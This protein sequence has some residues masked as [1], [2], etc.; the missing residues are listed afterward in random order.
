MTASISYSRLIQLLLLVAF[1]LN[2]VSFLQLPLPKFSIFFIKFFPIFILTALLFY[3]CRFSVRGFSKFY[4]A[5]LVGVF[6]FFSLVYVFSD[7]A[8]EYV[9]LYSLW[10]WFYFIIFFGLS[11]FC[12]HNSSFSFDRFFVSVFWAIVFISC[13]SIIAIYLD[14]PLA[15]YHRYTVGLITKE[16]SGLFVST[17]YGTYFSCIALLVG[18][19]LRKQ[20][21]SIPFLLA[22]GIILL[23]IMLYHS[24]SQVLLLIA[25]LAVYTLAYRKVLLLTTCVFAS[26]I[27]AFFFQGTVEILN[28]FLRY[29]V[30][31]ERGILGNR[32]II[33]SLYWQVSDYFFWSGIGPG[34]TRNLWPMIQVSSEYEYLNFYGLN[35][36]SSFFTNVIEF[37]V[38]FALFLWAGYISV[39]F[40]SALHENKDRK[41]LVVL[42]AFILLDALLNDD[43]AYPGSPGT[44]IF[45]TVLA[46]LHTSNRKTGK[47]I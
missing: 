42:L 1:T 38:F 28:A 5:I 8:S 43:I 14:L 31:V 6:P 17:N 33:Y 36:H 15:T 10:A 26:I 20:I 18:F 24:R 29:D 12:L 2:F 25:C 37:G 19:Y 21:P 30:L 45:M 35:A 7:F 27:M 41:M 11:G 22:M 46:A 40:K 4:G 13:S 16:Y 23:S 32:S 3:W 44:F 39:L 34:S 47:E 9:I